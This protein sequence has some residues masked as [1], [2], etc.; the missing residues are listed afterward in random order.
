MIFVR[1]SRTRSSSTWASAILK[2]NPKY[3]FSGFEPR[4]TRTSSSTCCVRRASASTATA[5]PWRSA[6]LDERALPA[7]LFG[8]VDCRLLRPLAR[9][10][11]LRVFFVILVPHLVDDFRGDLAQTLAEALSMALN[12]TES[13]IASLLAPHSHHVD[14]VDSLQLHS[15]CMCRQGYSSETGSLQ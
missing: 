6:F 1:T 10:R 13:T 3:S 7:A 15:E 2:A 5:R 9:S 12:G 11:G 4:T 14:R 8:P